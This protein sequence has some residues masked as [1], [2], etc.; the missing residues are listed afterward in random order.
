MKKTSFQ[1]LNGHSVIK[2]IY[3]HKIIRYAGNI[4]L[5]KRLAEP[6]ATARKRSDFCGSH[7]EVDIKVKDGKISEFCQDVDACALGSA[8]ASIVA[9]YIIGATFDEVLQ[10]Q[11]EMW[12]ML[13]DKGD[14]PSGRF[15][16]LEIL[17]SI[18]EHPNRHASTMLVLD[19][20]VTAIKDLK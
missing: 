15:A 1:V 13:K 4:P 5:H 11:I 16:E 7:I 17:Q 10:T 6:D 20:L 2:K 12:N 9:E 8:A 3:S 19:A 14:V 18:A